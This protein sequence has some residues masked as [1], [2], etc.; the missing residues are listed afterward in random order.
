[1]TEWNRA[2]YFLAENLTSED[3]K[4]IVYHYR[5]IGGLARVF[6]EDPSY[7]LEKTKINLFVK[8]AANALKVLMKDPTVKVFVESTIEK[9]SKEQNSTP[10]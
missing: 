5:N 10:T 9:E 4:S 2:K 7:V 3:L 1:M 6:Y 8:E